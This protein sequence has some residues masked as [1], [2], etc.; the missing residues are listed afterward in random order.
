MRTTA[1]IKKPTQEPAPDNWDPFFIK[2]TPLFWP[3]SPAFNR[4]QITQTHWPSLADY[5][6]CLGDANTFN[7][8]KKRITFVNQSASC[9]TFESEY[10]PRIYCT[11]EVQ[12]RLNNWHDFFQVMVWKTFSKTKALLNQI[13][14]N[15]AVKR[16]K[17]KIKQRGKEENFVTLF[18]E[19]GTVVVSNNIST[20]T[21]VKNFEWDKFFVKNKMQFG[22][23][24]DCIVFGHAMYEKALKPYIGMTSHCL[25]L[26]VETDYFQLSTEKKTKHIDTLLTKYI[27]QIEDLNTKNLT[28]LPILGVPSWH[29]NQS[30]DFYSNRAYFRAGRR[31]K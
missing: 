7:S 26:P 28:P 4:L 13:H 31:E 9:N 12:T 23:T 5:N 1:T 19:C 21:L 17:K 16:H 15:A 18:D 27:T 6:Q 11:G 25:L 29:H 30:E 14:F 8:N 3:I 20:L 10:E 22:K 24:I 2:L